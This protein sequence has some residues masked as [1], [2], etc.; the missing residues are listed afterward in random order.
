MAGALVKIRSG[1]YVPSDLAA[2]RA[3]SAR[4]DAARTTQENARH[5]ANS[6]ALSANAANSPS[7]RR[8]LRMRSRYEFGNNTYLNGIVRTLANDTIGSGPRL[9]MHTGDEF[10]D[11]RIEQDFS[12][13]AAAVRLSQ[14]LNTMRQSKARDGEVFGMLIRNPVIALRSGLDI[15]LDLQL[16]EAEMVASSLFEQELADL[17]SDGIKLDKLGNPV[18]YNVLPEHPGGLGWTA[19]LVKAIAVRAEC[20]TH[21]FSPDRPGQVRGIPETTPALPIFA[22]IRR[23]T[24]ATLT[25][26]EN[27]ANISGVITTR[28]PE[29]AAN[30]EEAPNVGE[31][32]SLERG[33]FLTLP[34]GW[35]LGQP[36]AEQPTAT[37]VEFKRSMI[38]ES[39]RCFNMPYNIA[40]GDSSDYNYASGRLDH[41]TYYK[42]IEVER[43]LAEAQ[44]MEPVVRNWL[45]EWQMVNGIALSSRAHEWFW[46]G[47]GHIDPQKEANS[48]LVRLRSGT[49]TLQREYARQGLDWR[50]ERRKA[51]E[52]FGLSEEEYCRRLAASIFEQ[53]ITINE[54][55]ENEETKRR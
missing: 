16:L 54:A 7:V 13:W 11:D 53:P 12:T 14:K 38:S 9:Q 39:A 27:I 24:L 36:K 47:F 41:Q 4:Y 5:W 33:Q 3:V 31:A 20:M 25:A 37:Y 10:L 52:S 48:T 26:A 30:S 19:G 46:D 21:Y 8:T 23:W 40:A 34:E 22:Q 6:D 44:V 29:L 2:Q 49:T 55:G 28:V 17:E 35:E 1:L 45:D 51:A 18:S 50:V 32:I 43:R 15:E 42:S